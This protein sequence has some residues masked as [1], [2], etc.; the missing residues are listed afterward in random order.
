MSEIS[1][2][3]SDHSIGTHTPNKE[4]HHPRDGVTVVGGGSPPDG[5]QFQTDPNPRPSSFLCRGNFCPRIFKTGPRDIVVGSEIFVFT[6]S[7]SVNSDD[8]LH[9]WGQAPSIEV[10]HGMLRE[11]LSEA[12]FEERFFVVE[13]HDGSVT[14]YEVGNGSENIVNGDLHATTTGVRTELIDLLLETR[15]QEDDRVY[16]Y[17]N[18]LVSDEY[19]YG[20][21]FPS[22]MDAQNSFYRL[23]EID[24]E[25]VITPHFGITSYRAHPDLLPSLSRDTFR[26]FAVDWATRRS[27]FEAIFFFNEVPRFDLER[28]VRLSEGER[29]HLAVQQ[30]S[31]EDWSYPDASF[32]TDEVMSLSFEA[33]P[34]EANAS[35]PPDESAIASS[36]LDLLWRPDSAEGN[37][38]AL[39][40]NT[41]QLSRFQ[42]GDEIVLLRQDG[43][44]VPYMSLESARCLIGISNEALQDLACRSG[45]CSLRIVRN[46][47]TLAETPLE[48]TVT[49]R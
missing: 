34:E 16:F 25:R 46:G 27:G 37:I 28:D 22:V 49:L 36:P 18:H 1:K 17:H 3:F 47:E 41:E 44:T 40:E 2:I 6:E 29:L 15:T 45:E 4:H 14:W 8:G 35:C 20:S 7:P 23:D 26:Q 24:A 43:S 39:G 48:G 13:G 10:F 31:E 33:W 12:E 19:D 30:A 21:I 42:P 38:I 11:S 5:T 32:R 9:Q